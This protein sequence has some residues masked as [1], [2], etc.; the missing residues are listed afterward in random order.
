MSNNFPFF[1]Y[2][3]LDEY[4]D[5]TN[6]SGPILREKAG[7][8]VCVQGGWIWTKECWPRGSVDDNEPGVHRVFCYRFS[9]S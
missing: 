1:G 5:F 8:L 2:T 6:L 9:N 7:R 3:I 4:Y